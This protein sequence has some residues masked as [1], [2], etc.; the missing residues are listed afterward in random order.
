[1]YFVQYKNGL[2]GY[3]LCKFET[4]GEAKEFIYDLVNKGVQEFYVSKEI[5]V[6]VKM[7]VEF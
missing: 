2:F 7:E 1:M 6:S 5:P 4:F 3:N